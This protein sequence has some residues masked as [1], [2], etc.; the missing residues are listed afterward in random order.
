MT[1][2]NI[3]QKNIL[4]VDDETAVLRSVSII[5]QKENYKIATATSL[6][7]ASSLLIK[8]NYDIVLTDLCLGEASGL[9]LVREIAARYPETETILLTGYGTIKSFHSIFQALPR[10]RYG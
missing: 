7:Q 6:E 5:L 3:D 1:E 8:N 9:E 10:L 4:I 2:K